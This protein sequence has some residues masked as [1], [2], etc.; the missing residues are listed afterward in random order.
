MKRLNQAGFYGR[1]INAKIQNSRNRKRRTKDAD[2]KGLILLFLHLLICV[3][4]WIGIRRIFAE[5]YLMVP[6]MHPVLSV[7][8]VRFSWQFF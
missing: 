3:L 2:N 6:M 7:V 4:T 8:Q 1:Q 5:R